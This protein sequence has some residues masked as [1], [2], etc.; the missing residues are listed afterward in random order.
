MQAV[1]DFPDDTETML[2][3]LR[4]VTAMNVYLHGMSNEIYNIK[5]ENQNGIFKRNNG[6]KFSYSVFIAIRKTFGC[7]RMPVA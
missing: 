7:G 1:C 2:Y 5:F 6:L 3:L 4:A